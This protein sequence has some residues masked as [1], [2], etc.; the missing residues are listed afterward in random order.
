MLYPQLP[1]SGAL[2]SS[3]PMVRL[4]APPGLPPPPPPG[5]RGL[6]PDPAGPLGFVPELHLGRF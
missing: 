6:L 5:P 4:G 3:I 1:H 2:T